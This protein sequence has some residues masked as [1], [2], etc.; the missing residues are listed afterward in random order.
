MAKNKLLLVSVFGPYGFKDEYA[1]ATGMQMELLN[2]QMTREQGVHSP[3]F[4]DTY[5]NALY[6]LARNI[7][8]ETVVLDFPLWK[9]F[10]E[11]LK[12]G[13]THVGISFLG[14]NAY[15]AERMAKYI[16]KNYPETKIILG[17]GGTVIPDLGDLI[18][19]DAACHG[20]GIRWLRE[21]FGEDPEAPIKRCVVSG[22]QT[23]IIYGFKIKSIVSSIFPG[24]GCPNGCDF[25][26]TSHKFGAKYIPFIKTGKE[27]LRMLSEEEEKYGQQHFM[28]ED[29]NFLKQKERAIVL[30]N[31]MEK[32]GKAYTYFIFSSVESIMELGID[33]LV[34]LGTEILWIGVE[35]GNSTYKKNRDADLH[36]LIEEL[37]SNGI[38]IIGSSILFLDHHTK[39]NIMDNIDWSVS[40]GTDLHQ[41]M[42]LSPSPGTPLWDRLTSENRILED[43]HLGE[44]SGLTKIWF[45]H[46][47]FK[48]EETDEYIKKAFQKNFLVNGPCL[49]NMA[50]TSIRGYK[51]ALEDYHY[52]E[53]NGLA[54]NAEKRCYEK[55]TYPEQDE[56][57]KLRLE[58]MKTK[59]LR[60]R[61]IFLTIKVL[62][63][64][65]ASR[66]KCNMVFNMYNEVFGKMNLNDRIK[67]FMLLGFALV[68]A[69][70]IKTRKLLGKGDIIRQPSKLR[71]EYN[72]EKGMQT[73]YDE[74]SHP[75]LRPLKQKQIILRE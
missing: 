31:E 44:T 72:K 34:R 57:F 49:L 58:S 14:P 67:S 1:E 47:H 4:K 64:N 56:F 52:R 19:H 2:N 61:P 13:Y 68:E 75:V 62:S 28:I 24:V 30:L 29:E 21:Y 51:K 23:H 17:N 3:R 16:R 37:R 38:K 53:K 66:E 5:T 7:S 8:V 46:P 59:T 43:V 71:M 11:E 25:C 39:E 60:Y 36:A 63:P 65:R 70:R 18:P 26:H 74:S 69:F 48:P 33:F 41:F 20:E 9:D 32:G 45:K 10:I 42:A 50:H 73:G 54:W 40:L 15:K 22:R 35:S 12:N 27:M 6:L 55:V